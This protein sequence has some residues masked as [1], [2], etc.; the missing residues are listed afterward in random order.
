MLKRSIIGFCLAFLAA[1]AALAEPRHGIAMHGEPK[2]PAGFGH[3][4]Y[5]NPDAPKGGTLRLAAQNTFDSL[6]PF[7]V[8]GV[9]AAGASLP[10]E[11]LMVPSADEPFSMYG[12]LAES[13]ETPPD[14]S[15]ATFT[16]RKEARW[17]DGTPVTPEDVIFSLDI[18]KTKGEPN[19]R[20]YYGAVDK[21]EKVGPRSV[22]FT[23]K[24]GD[25][26]ELPLIVGEMPILPR[27]YWQGRDFDKTTLEPPL[28]SGPYRVGRFEPGRFIEYERVPDYWGADLPVRKG[29]F[30]FDR[31]R[32]DY[33]R[34]TTVALE[35]LKAGEYD[36]REE[37]EAKKWATGY[38]DWAALADGRAVKAELD[39]EVPAGMQAFAYNTRR[40]LFADPRVRRA[41]ALAFDFEWTNRNLFYGQYTRSSSYWS[42][43]ELAATGLPSPAEL[44]VL[45]P[46][47]GQVPE[48]V[49]TK[50][51]A[52][53]STE[54]LES[55]RPNLR[56]AMALLEE[57][58]WRVVD[59][60]VV[61]GRLVK[62]GRPF[63]FE[64]LLAQPTFERIALPFTRNL[65]RL[66]IEARVR[67]VDASQYVNRLREFDYDMIV[68]SWGQ[69]LSPGNEQ[70]M[71]WSSEAADQPGSRNFVG[72]RNP[73]V[74]R[75]V[76]GVISA[77]DRDELVART[78]ALDR[79]L[80]WN[81]YVIPQ[82]HIGY[83]RVAHWDKFG[84]PDVTPMRGY[85]LFA[86]WS[87][88]AAQ[89]VAAPGLIGA[90]QA[91]EQPPPP[92]APSPQLPR[93][94]P[95]PPSVHG[96]QGGPVVSGETVPRPAASSWSPSIWVW[97]G[98]ALIVVVVLIVRRRQRGD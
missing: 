27:H 6:N 87:K 63:S 5:V 14:R 33:Y 15:W 73:A 89:S 46:L 57:A 30:N 32:Y 97:V 10:F 78:R 49:F 80:L 69:S 76:A 61:D 20:F 66:G 90:A 65:A 86:W 94:G 60:R 47:R 53:P 81:H 42:N 85:Q 2:Y 17:H 39:N 88:D 38:Q 4:A 48:E 75:L 41:L 68:A 96:E 11:T 51:Y 79:V 72:I 3:F 83:D 52:P 71:F 43:S 64:I 37:N 8:K 34:D 29:Q 31:L 9:S 91:Q 28:G 12:L 1:T 24:P 54:G 98:L 18:L 19:Y 16:L 44:E 77:R 62:D 56:E 7:I 67:T 55:I 74:D 35:A 36:F 93:S 21:A 84:R 45:E 26:H 59:G 13:I 22:K 23:F 95:P 92:Q 82:W 70:A 40:D 25:N 58:G 50:A